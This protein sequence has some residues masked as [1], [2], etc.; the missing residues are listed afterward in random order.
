MLEIGIVKIKLTVNINYPDP[1]KKRNPNIFTVEETINI[2]EK[3]LF[4][5]PDHLQPLK[6]SLYMIPFNIDHE[7]HTNKN[8]QQKYQI[9]KQFSKEDS[10]NNAKNYFIIRRRGNLIFH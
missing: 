5:I 7:L 1:Y 4:T 6:N 3:T 8:I 2:K 10:N 9:I